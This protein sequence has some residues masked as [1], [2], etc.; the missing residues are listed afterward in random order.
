MTITII[1]GMSIN[2]MGI[3]TYSVI[4]IIMIIITINSSVNLNI[5]KIPPS[6]G[7]NS[8][9]ISVIIYS[10]NFGE[11]VLRRNMYYVVISI[12]PPTVTCSTIIIMIM[13]IRFHD[14]Y[15]ECVLIWYYDWPFFWFRTVHD[16][17]G[18]SIIV[19]PYNIILCLHNPHHD[20]YQPPFMGKTTN[21]VGSIIITYYIGCIICRIENIQRYSMYE[22]ISSFF[23]KKWQNFPSSCSLWDQTNQVVL[24]FSLK[25]DETRNW[26]KRMFFFSSLICIP[27]LFLFFLVPI[28]NQM[29]VFLFLVDLSSSS[30][31]RTDR[32]NKTKTKLF[33]FFVIPNGSSFVCWCWNYESGF[34]FTLPQRLEIGRR[35][36]LYIGPLLFLSAWVSQSWWTWSY[37]VEEKEGSIVIHFCLLIYCWWYLDLIRIWIRLG[38]DWTWLDLTWLSSTYIYHLEWRRRQLYFSSSSHYFRFCRTRS[39]YM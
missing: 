31:Y 1:G 30:L 33:V 36:S 18:C 3:M 12:N 37:D 25:I 17:M 14:H 5:E 21:I 34:F 15:F 26:Q 23:S 27:Q 19:I 9:N 6:P 20:Y 24:D 8:S 7:S 32:R 28:K 10:Y 4:I 39:Q 13:I 38:F 16:I 2:S 35:T 11:Y 22:I 29:D